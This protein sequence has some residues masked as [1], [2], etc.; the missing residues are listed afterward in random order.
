MKRGLTLQLSLMLLLT[1]WS[2]T[3]AAPRVLSGPSSRKTTDACRATAQAALRACRAEAQSDKALALGKCANLPDVGAAKACNQQASLDV[4]DA[5]TTCKDQHDARRAVCAKLGPAP[6]APA[7]DPA[8]FT[9]AMGKPLPIDN[10]LFPLPPGTTFVYEGQTAAGFERDEFAVTHNTRTILGVTCVEVHDTVTTGGVLTED[11]LD[12]FAEDK[13][14]NVWYFGENS[15]Q[16]E[17]GLVVGIEG[18]WTGGVDGGV[19]GI[20]MEAHPVLGDFY[21]QEFL[22]KDAEDVAE[23]S[24]VDESVTL[25]NNNTTYPH[26]LKTTETAPIEPDALENKFYAP[27]VGTVLVVDVTAGE[28]SEL[29]QVI[30]GP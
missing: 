4:K 5:L 7:I 20:V 24:S 2:L 11:T 30:T 21:R 14:G 29:V 28:R 3:S 6:Y 26:C 1:G 16:I 15:K 12:W 9:D 22:L 25:T 13:A 10:V 17:G 23:V 19:P 8:N 27:N 18:T